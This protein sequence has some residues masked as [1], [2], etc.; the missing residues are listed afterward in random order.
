MAPKTKGG[1]R[2]AGRRAEEPDAEVDSLA[3]MAVDDQQGAAAVEH[4]SVRDPELA[5]LL[6]ETVPLV[7]TPRRWSKRLFLSPALR[8]PRHGNAAASP[9]RALID[10]PPTLVRT[11][12]RRILLFD[13]VVA[14]AAA[15]STTGSAGT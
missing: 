5:D 14:A 9:Q 11:P 15:A 3:A 7:K 12:P 6:D 1:G 10:L 4:R 13:E 2:A 8:K